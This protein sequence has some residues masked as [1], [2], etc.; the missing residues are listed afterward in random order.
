[1]E[2]C[3]FSLNPHGPIDFISRIKSRKVEDENVGL[4][5]LLILFEIESGLMKKPAAISSRDLGLE[6]AAVCGKYFL[7]IEHLHYGYWPEDLPVRIDS[8][9]TLIF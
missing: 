8:R 1:M 7:G 6:F 3:G 4:L 5:L 2:E 9:T